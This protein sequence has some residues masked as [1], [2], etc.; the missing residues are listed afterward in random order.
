MIFV[1]I[2][3]YMD[4]ELPKT[5]NDLLT[6][7][8]NPD[9]IHIGI[10]EQHARGKQHDFS[11]NPN[12]RTSNILAQYAKGA[13]YA[14][15][16]AMDLYQGE[17]YFFQIDS[18][19][20]FEKDWDSKLI[21][22]L[23]QAQQLAGT[24]KVILSQYPAPYFI[25]SDNKDH[26]PV[27][28]SLYWSKPTW[29][30][31]VN[32]AHGHWAAHRQEIKDLTKP[33]P[34]HTI[35][36]GYVFSIGDIVNEI[37]YDPRI[38]FMGEELCFAVRAYTRGWEIYSPQEMLVYHFYKRA[39]YPKIWNTGALKDKW[40]GFEKESYQVQKD[41]LMGIEDGVY[42][43]EDYE[44]FLDYQEMIGIDFMSFYQSD[45]QT[46][47]ANL[48]VVEQ[49]IDFLDTPMRSRYCI[50]DIHDECKHIDECQC[51]CHRRS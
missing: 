9:E 17:D 42:G 39:E 28:D 48:S 37:P 46:I 50:L 51:E 38:S 32:T 31:V 4:P 25:G 3:S 8:T 45:I 35:L 40:F 6:K 43:I 18:H 12:I 14:R 44:R 33:H 49:E 27:D 19:M 47:K 41:V 22:I 10:V 11:S 15:K 24:P 23:G 29:S 16:L 36:A 30:R 2:A 21:S 26:F 13:G 7:A 20:R 5:V 34:S 1:S